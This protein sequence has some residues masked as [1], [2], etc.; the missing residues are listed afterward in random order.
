MLVDQT[1]QSPTVQLRDG[2]IEFELLWG[3]WNRS[4]ECESSASPHG[5][6]PPVF[7]SALFP[8][9]G[10]F[11]DHPAFLLI[12]WSPEHTHYSKWSCTKAMSA[13]RLLTSWLCYV[14]KHGLHAWL[15]GHTAVS[16]W[17]CGHLLPLD[18]FLQCCS[19]TI[20]LPDST[21]SS[22]ELG[23]YLCGISCYLLI[24]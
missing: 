22:V 1:A 23:T 9:S 6:C 18:T 15:P 4:R 3:S 13:S 8:S 17:A 2:L 21:I 16:L 20:H 24:V 5:I 12:L 7:L 19:P 11:Q 10:C 14:C